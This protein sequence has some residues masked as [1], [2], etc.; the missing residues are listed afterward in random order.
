MIVFMHTNTLA[1]SNIWKLTKSVLSLL[2]DV[3]SVSTM[4]LSA[5]FQWHCTNC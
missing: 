5:V 3:P 1:N 4:K 2:Q